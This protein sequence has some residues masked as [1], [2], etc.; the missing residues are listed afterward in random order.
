VQSHVGS[1]SEFQR[2]KEM[3]GANR[4][5]A[6]AA[7]LAGAAGIAIGPAGLASAD[8]ELNG[9]Y[10]FSVDLT[11]ATAL[12]DPGVKTHA[13]AITPCGAGCAHVTLPG[14]KAIAG[15]N[16]GG[17]LHLVNGRWEMTQ[18]NSIMH[19]GAGPDVTIVTSLDAA[20]LQGT[21]DTTNHCVGMSYGGPATLT[22]A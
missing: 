11:Q 20:T 12:K 1:L 21:Q 17:D 9:T 22:R 15:N 7:V 10:N 5:L 6:S 8:P 4:V 18:E 16:P 2:E 3:I 19:C 14:A 13:W